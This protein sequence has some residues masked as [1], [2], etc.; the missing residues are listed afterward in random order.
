MRY[1][2]QLVDRIV[3]GAQT[4]NK[5]AFG[6]DWKIKAVNSCVLQSE[7]A[8]AMYGDDPGVMA[9]V[10]VVSHDH[11]AGVAKYRYSLRSKA[12]YGVD[13]SEF[14]KQYGGGGHKHSSGMVTSFQI[15]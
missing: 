6:K 14:A 2:K 13:V 10:W 12:P 5:T 7:V 11:K 8:E 9:V 15:L 4:I 3:A 1:R